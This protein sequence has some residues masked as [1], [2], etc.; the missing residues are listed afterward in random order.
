M[1]R[2]GRRSTLLVGAVVALAIAVPV[3]GAD[4]T[5]SPGPPG[6]TKPDKT[7]KPDKPEK[8][9]EVAVTV[10]G[11]VTQGTDDKGRPTFSLTAGGTTWSLS[12]G[13]AWYWGD[14]NPLK[15][16]VGDQ[17]TITGSHR[18]GDTELDVATVDGTAIRAAGKPAWA[19]GP[20]RVG[21]TH[22]GWK[23]WMADGK[24]G[25]GLGREGAPGQLKKAADGG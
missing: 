8:A 1:K 17:V 14:K 20:W 11:T 3:M 2:P 4:P 16:H 24:P 23:D 21:E 18:T 7:A 19:G 25:K 10:T 6:Q 22:P 9:P 13:P 5:P 12:A 15:A